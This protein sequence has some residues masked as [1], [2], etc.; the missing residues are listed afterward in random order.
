MY[1]TSGNSNINIFPINCA[2]LHNNHHANLGKLTTKEKW[3]E[4]DPVVNI[5]KVVAK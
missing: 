2:T 1:H 4:F 3:W 5:C